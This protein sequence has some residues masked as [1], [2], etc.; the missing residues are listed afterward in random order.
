MEIQIKDRVFDVEIG[1]EH[2]G[3]VVLIPLANGLDKKVPIATGKTKVAAL[4]NAIKYLIELVKLQEE[5]N[6]GCTAKE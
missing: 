6:A 5:E 4:N 2:P 3:Y 1:G